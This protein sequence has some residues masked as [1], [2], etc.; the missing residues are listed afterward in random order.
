MHRACL[1]VHVAVFCEI[2]VRVN[3]REV[4]DYMHSFRSSVTDL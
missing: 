3:E 1:D 2:I 4:A